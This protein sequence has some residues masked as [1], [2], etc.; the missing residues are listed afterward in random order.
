MN[1]PKIVY[2]QDAMCGWCYAFGRVMDEMQLK[3][4]DFFDFI[5]VSGGLIVGDAIA[6]IG[7]MKEFLKDAMPKVEDYTG[8]K[9]GEKYKELVEEGSYMNNSIK[10]AIALSAFKS[11]LPFRSVEFA[12]DIQYEHFYNGRDL[13]EKEVYMELAAN[14][15]VDAQDLVNRMNSEQFQKITADEFEHIK[16]IGITSYP[17]V[18]GETEKGIYLLTKGYIHEEEMDNIIASFRQT[19]EQGETEIEVNN[20]QQ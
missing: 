6:P 11:I 20:Q 8:V 19:V 5:A 18:L 4:S 2:V 10:P 1:K 3:H 7:N 13:N 17:C 12:H 9:F 15:E 14:Y 16:K